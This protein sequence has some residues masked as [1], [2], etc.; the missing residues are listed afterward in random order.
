MPNLPP[1]NLVAR[2]IPRAPSSERSPGNPAIP[3][4][5]FATP[6]P[7]DFAMSAA[8]TPDLIQGAS[9]KS[10]VTH[11]ASGSSGIR[12]SLRNPFGPVPDADALLELLFFSYFRCSFSSSSR[13][14][15]SSP[16][17]AAQTADGFLRF[18]RQ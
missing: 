11:G 10:F 17:L 18:R 9:G 1:I 4:P 12:P 13:S 3:I 16:A 5:P 14:N 8:D 7:A 2:S 6:T 15:R